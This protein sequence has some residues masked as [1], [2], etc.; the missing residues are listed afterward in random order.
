MIMN[1]VVQL[2]TTVLPGGKNEVADQDL[3]VG[4]SVCV[5]VMPAAPPPRRSAVD[6][7]AEAQGHRLFSTAADVASYFGAE[8]AA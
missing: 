4:Q 1:R 8:R 7:L 6:I 2:M 3:P 5:V